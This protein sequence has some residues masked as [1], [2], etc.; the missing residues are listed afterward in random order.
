MPR[1]VAISGPGVVVLVPV[2]TR[3]PE[4]PD[5]GAGAGQT[6]AE[7]AADSRLM[8]SHPRLAAVRAR[9]FQEV[10]LD[11]TKERLPPRRAFAAQWISES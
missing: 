5:H 9:C 1:T 4:R 3:W 2:D 11:V 8:G 6:G 7:R 10:E